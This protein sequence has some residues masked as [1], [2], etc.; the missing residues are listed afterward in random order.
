MLK[1][2]YADIQRIIKT[3]SNEELFEKKRYKWK[4]STS[5]GSYLVSAT[6][7]NYDWA[8]KLMKKALK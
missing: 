1:E 7:S 6:S 3:H 4:G 5:M 8:H 2:P